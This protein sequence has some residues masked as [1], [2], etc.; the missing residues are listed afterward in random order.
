MRRI[1]WGFCINQFGI[2]LLQYISSLSDFNFEFAE[3]FVIG[4]GESAR[5]PIN[6]IVFKPLNKTMIIVH[7]IPG[8]FLAKL[9]L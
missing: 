3:I 9:V 1:F 8:L 2:G 5:L 6:T 7:Y 4:V